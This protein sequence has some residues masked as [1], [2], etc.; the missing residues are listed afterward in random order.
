MGFEKNTSEITT[1][2]SF[3]ATKLVAE[4]KISLIA[5]GGKNQALKPES[6]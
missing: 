4:I 5:G 6:V 2:Q 3:H 1:K